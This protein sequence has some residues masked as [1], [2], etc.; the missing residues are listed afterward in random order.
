MY[1]F[2]TSVCSCVIETCIYLTFLTI[3]FYLCFLLAF[4]FW[5][6]TIQQWISQFILSIMVF[7]P[8]LNTLPLSLLSLVTQ[9]LLV[10]D[11]TML[12]KKA[13]GT[14]TE[15]HNIKLQNYSGILL[16][17]SHLW[18][19]HYSH[20]KSCSVVCPCILMYNTTY[21]HMYAHILKGQCV[22]IV[23]PCEAV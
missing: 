6:K 17:G 23:Y 11:L 2:V 14:Y 1:S 4:V 10:T 12:Q 8:T 19:C 15:H 13:L 21:V 7:V 3:L 16:I 20:E 9:N 5:C 22:G 18:N